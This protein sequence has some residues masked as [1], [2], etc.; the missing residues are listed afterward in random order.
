[1]GGTILY[2]VNPTRSTTN[3]Y[4]LKVLT[5]VTECDDGLRMPDDMKCSVGEG[6]DIKRGAAGHVT[7]TYASGGQ[8]VTSSGH[9]I[10]LK[11]I[12][13]SLE[14]VLRVVQHEFGEEE[15]YSLRQ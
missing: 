14:S 2:T 3:L 11:K 10:E 9:W 12:D 5:V 15:V 13:T 7:L 1:M 4:D 8:L 6:D